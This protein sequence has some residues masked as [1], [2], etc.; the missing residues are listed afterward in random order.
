[1]EEFKNIQL[2]NKA[3]AIIQD[4]PALQKTGLIIDIKTKEPDTGVVVLA[5]PDL[6]DKLDARVKV[7]LSHG[8]KLTIRGV[9]VL[10]FRD[11]ESSI[12]FAYE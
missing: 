3:F 5:G 1:M 4:E 2:P 10:Y 7:R 9:E 8:E 11:Y 6:Q 12:Y